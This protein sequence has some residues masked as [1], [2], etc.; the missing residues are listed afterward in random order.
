MRAQLLVGPALGIALVGCSTGG[1]WQLDLGTHGSSLTGPSLGAQVLVSDGGW[2]ARGASAEFIDAYGVALDPLG[3]SYLAGSYTGT[4]SLLSGN[5]TSVGQFEPFLQ[6]YSPSGS[7]SWD[8][9]LHL[10]TQHDSGVARA[11]GV[12]PSG[13]SYAAGYFSGTLQVG[14]SPI[15]STGTEDAFVVSYDVTGSL[16][17]SAHFGGS[18]FCIAEALAV[19]Q[20]G[21]VVV[22]GNFSGSCKLGL[23]SGKTTPPFNFADCAMGN[24]L[25]ENNASVTAPSPAT[26]SVGANSSLS[27]SNNASVSG[28]GIC[29]GAALAQNSA[30]LTGQLS[31][32]GTFK[33]ENHASVGRATSVTPAPQPCTSTF[34]LAQALAAAAAANDNALLQGEP[35]FLDGAIVLQNGS[36]S[37]LPAGTFYVTS[38][39][40]S[41]NANLVAS[42]GTATIYVQG[43]VVV[44][45]NAF[46]GGLPG[47]SGTVLVVSGADSTK[48][49]QVVVENNADAMLS[50]YA[51]LADVT[52]QNN[53]KI[54][55]AVVGN[56]VTLSN[57]QVLVYEPGIMLNA[58]GNDDLFLIDLDP[59]SGNVTWV[60]QFTHTSSSGPPTPTAL[61]NGIGVDT[62]GDLLLA[63]AFEGSVQFGVESTLTSAGGE[64][65]FVAKL[66]STGNPIW[67]AAYGGPADQIAYGVA[68]DPQGNIILAGAFQGTLAFRAISLTSA[69]GTDVF[70]AKI[71]PSGNPLWAEAFGDPA[72]QA[73]YGVAA[74]DESNVIATGGFDGAIQWG[75]TTLTSAGSSDIFVGKLDSSLSLIGGQ[76]RRSRDG[77]LRR[78]RRDDLLPPRRTRRKRPWNPTRWKPGATRPL[79]SQRTPSPPQQRLAVPA[80]A[81]RDSGST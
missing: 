32:G 10:A 55:G 2:S 81:G 24:L 42:G 54:Y 18:S 33:L 43:N 65:V 30:Q 35:Y 16:R 72:D 17:W 53:A 68:T 40:I 20:H 31:Y 59:S 64:D 6:T 3:N 77:F 78:R 50:F 1:D 28:N 57:N 11:V 51:P 21:D 8:R 79:G 5:E 39:S 44:Q 52:L 26:A 46:L 71:D 29:G 48:G 80:S 36:T 23:P 47:E 63:G 37:A 14:A 62:A 75:M 49:G 73:A 70:V 27:L 9:V 66:D 38:L 69:G 58:G 25:I 13:N 7:P 41:N 45:N 74:D 34:D 19:G 22:G 12:D 60:R 56:N 61:F 4:V 67:S 76:H 15:A